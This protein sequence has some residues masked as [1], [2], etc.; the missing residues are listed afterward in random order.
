MKLKN[1]IEEIKKVNEKLKEVKRKKINIFNNK[2][3]EVKQ[4]HS[5]I[6]N[7]LLKNKNQHLLIKESMNNENNLDNYNNIVSKFIINKENLNRI[8]SLKSKIKSK[9]EK[10]NI[11]TNIKKIDEEIKLINEK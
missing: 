9:E 8:A 11:K 6:N 3:N 1:K 4:F 7:F 2:I 10:E 5:K